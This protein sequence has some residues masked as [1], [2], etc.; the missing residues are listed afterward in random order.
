MRRAVPAMTNLGTFPKLSE[1][2]HCVEDGIL[3]TATQMIMQYVASIQE[4]V[5]LLDIVKMKAS[6]I[7]LATTLCFTR[8]GKPR[9]VQSLKSTV[10]DDEFIHAAFYSYY[11]FLLVPASDHCPPCNLPTDCEVYLPPP[12]ADSSHPCP[13]PT[14]P[15]KAHG[16]KNY[17]FVDIIKL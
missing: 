15:I 10:S 2:A 4:K 12:A 1:H 3:C 9:S 16:K 11:C 13:C 8:A 7:L 6:V 17:W 14:C 5:N